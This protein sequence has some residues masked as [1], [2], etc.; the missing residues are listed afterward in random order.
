MRSRGF[1]SS[2][3]FYEEKRA[4]RRAFCGEKWGE[5]G[6][7]LDFDCRVEW[8]CRAIRDGALRSENVAA[9]RRT[10]LPRTSLRLSAAICRTTLPRTSLRSSAPVFS[11]ILILLFGTSLRSFRRRGSSPHTPGK[12]LRLPHLFCC[13]VFGGGGLGG[14]FDFLSGMGDG[15]PSLDRFYQCQYLQWRP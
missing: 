5:Q 6:R 1:A 4:R 3:L 9:I 8:I 14:F 12:R 10:T 11:F 2:A 15:A 7:D 13:R